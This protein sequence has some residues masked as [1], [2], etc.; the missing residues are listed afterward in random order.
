MNSKTLCSKIDYLICMLYILVTIIIVV[1]SAVFGAKLIEEANL[2]LRS[3]EVNSAREGIV[4]NKDHSEGYTYYTTS[5]V[6]KT[7][8]TMPHIVPALYHM[9]I[10]IE[11]NDEKTE[12]TVDVSEEEYN[13]YEIGSTYKFR[14][15][16]GN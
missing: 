6:N 13:S 10:T 8:I 3:D 16:K 9:T 14:Q 4:S 11:D 5:Y 1:S 12:K 2:R 15:K 7:P